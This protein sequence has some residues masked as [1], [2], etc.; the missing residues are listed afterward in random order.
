MTSFCSISTWQAWTL[1]SWSPTRPF[2]TVSSVRFSVRFFFF[3]FFFLMLNKTTTT[4]TLSIRVYESSQRAE[5]DLVLPQRRHVSSVCQEGVGS[6]S[7]FAVRCVVLNHDE[8]HARK[9]Q[10]VRQRPHRH[11]STQRHAI[12]QQLVAERESSLSK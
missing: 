4:T 3:F 8:R 1:A 11:L 2:S 5:S 6:S 9:P 12:H 7:S 10:R